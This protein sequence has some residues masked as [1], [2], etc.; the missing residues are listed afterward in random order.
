MENTPVNPQILESLP[1]Y[2]KKATEEAFG[3][4]IEKIRLNEK[5]LAR[6]QTRAQEAL[7]EQPKS[8]FGDPFAMLGAMGMGYQSQPSGITFETLRNTSER[9]NIVA[10]IILTRVGQV[11]SFAKLQKNKYSVGFRI[12]PRGSYKKQLTPEQERRVTQLQHMLLNTGQEFSIGRD[13]FKTFLQKITRDRLTYD[14]MTFEKVPTRGG[15]IHSFF[16]VPGNTIRIATPNNVRSTPIPL[17][18]YKSRIKYVQLMHGTLVND[19]TQEQLAFC[20]GNPRTHERVGGYGFPEIEQLLTIITA[21]LWAQS[22]NMKQFSQGATL[23]GILNIQGAVPP[24]QLETFRRAWAA[25]VAGVDN[26]FKTPIMNATGIQWMPLQLSNQ[27]MGYQMWLEYLIKCITSVFMIDPSEINF[28]LRGS[29]MQ[30]PT[31]M[32]TNEAQQKVS[33]DKGLE[34]LLTFFADEINRHII[35]QLDPHYELTFSGLDAKT[36]EQAAQLRIQQGQ[37]YMTVNEIRALENLPPIEN[38]DIVLNPTYTGALQQKKAM[39]AQAAQGQQGQPNQEQGQQGMQG[40]PGKEEE[41]GA[42]NLRQFA[43]GKALKEESEEED[44]WL[45][46]NDW[47]STVQQSLK[48]PDL[49]KSNYY[50]PIDID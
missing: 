11:S 8:Y 5:E 24:A 28:D 23:K 37:N 45:D 18:E 27:E 32:S 6:E 38:G 44:N 36:E 10:A 49:R 7:P 4:L 48:S 19:Y 21:H 41:E 33:K 46:I 34:P 2:V 26:A 31:F 22:W 9:N 43:E 20:V 14:Q 12:V 1:E 3:N 30:Q 42:E 50:L 39:E 16:A 15:M 47:T 29:S 35:W 17:R 13:S 40:N 25:Q